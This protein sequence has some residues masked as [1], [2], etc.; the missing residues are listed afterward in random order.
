MV[1]R[2]TD[3]QLLFIATHKENKEMSFPE[4]ALAYNKKF[5]SNKSSDDIKHAYY[6]FSSRLTEKDNYASLLKKVNN[7]KKANRVNS[8]DLSK[9]LDQWEKREDLLDAIKT[10]AAQ[11]LKKATK[12]IKKISPSKNK[13][14]MTLELLLSDVH[15][16]KLTN[17]FNH[18]VLKSRL[19]QIAEVTI[20]EM[21]RASDHYNVSEIIIVCLGDMIESATMHGIE[22]MKSCEFGNSK[23]IQE[24]LEQLFNLVI[25]PIYDAAAKLGTK[26]T[27]IGVPGNH[28]RTEMNRTYTKP[29]EDNVTWIIYNSIKAFSDLLKY[30]IDF[31][32]SKEAYQYY[33]IYGEG[34]LYEHYD[35]VNGSNLRKGIETLMSKRVNQLKKPV[36][37]VRGGHFHEPC[38]FGVGKI[39]VNG[40]V[41]GN[42]GFSTTLG[43]DCE[44]S[45][46]L[47]FYIK[48]DKTDT[49]KR[50]TCF[51]KRF[52]IQLQ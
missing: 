32:I 37:F 19:N 21:I 14:S 1:F 44:P 20:K 9:V 22:S 28:D 12:P 38:E 45:Q 24:C 42:D 48:R 40:N 17:T 29:G 3:E 47:N 50:M 43:F 27:F 15:V 36:S 7:T 8:S 4:I 2:Y 11:V 35:N 6:R 18:E 23:Q 30:D 31:H 10:A 52:L 5:K 39:V 16:G 13:K 25:V 33:E 51:Y 26:V 34:V 49:I 46:T 41:P